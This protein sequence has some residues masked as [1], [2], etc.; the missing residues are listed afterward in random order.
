[1]KKF[2]ILI[3]IVLL[4]YTINAQRVVEKQITV[5]PATSL[6]LKLDFADSIRVIQSKDNTL[7]IKATVNINDN[8]HN[9][10]YELVTNEG[11]QTLTVSAKIHDM[12]SLRV[13]CKN[14]RGANYEYHDG[15][16]LTMDIYYII[17]V[18]TIANLKVE[19]ISGDIIID[20]ANNAMTLNTISGFI[21]MSIPAKSNADL[22]IE[23]VT[24]GVY[25]NHEF[26]KEKD[27]CDSSP[28]G[29]DVK[30]KIGSGGNRIKLETVSGDIF[31][32][33]I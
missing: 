14:R 31:L 26:N 11:E 10:K 20:N 2:S 28:G 21:D 29:T 12:K 23:T 27:N 22:K 24:G 13:P 16:C 9:D 8:Q 19:T 30:L 6:N 3:L 1:M 15:E 25:T 4:A 7:R 5:N 17:E 18:P 32:R 33:K